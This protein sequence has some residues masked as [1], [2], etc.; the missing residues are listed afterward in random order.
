MTTPMRARARVDD[1]EDARPRDATTAPRPTR[2]SASAS[3]R[4][5]RRR[6]ADETDARVA[7]MSAEVRALRETLDRLEREKLARVERRRDTARARATPST[8]SAATGRATKTPSSSSPPPRELAAAGLDDELA[9]ASR[10]RARCRA[11]AIDSSIVFDDASTPFEA[12]TRQFTLGVVKRLPEDARR[13][14]SDV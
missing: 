10:F 6:D 8:A 4:T 3:T 5:H 7:A 12:V 2:A 13:P 1:A 14:K 9:A 11:S